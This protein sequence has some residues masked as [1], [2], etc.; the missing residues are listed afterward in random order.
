[1]LRPPPKPPPNPPRSAERPANDAGDGDE[2]PNRLQ[3]FPVIENAFIKTSSNQLVVTYRVPTNP[4]NATYPLTIEFF[5]A[6]CGPNQAEACNA[7]E[8]EGMT[9]LA[10]DLYTPGDFGGGCGGE[11]CTSTVGL[12]L[13]NLLNVIAPGDYIVATATDAAGETLLFK[14]AGDNG[15]DLDEPLGNTSEFSAPQ[16][17]ELEEVDIALSKCLVPLEAPDKQAGNEAA[18]TS[19]IPAG[20]RQ[21]GEACHG[22]VP[23]DGVARR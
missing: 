18:C 14:Q 12:G 7:V 1:M 3:N 10:R 6:D 4:A 15:L 16:E 11:G 23:G 13:A 21:V 5:I 2:G 17:V 8:A 19:S 9:F 20:F 22:R